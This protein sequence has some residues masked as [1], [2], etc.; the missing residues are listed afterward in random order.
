MPLQRSLTESV[1]V[2]TGASSGI[3]A[4]T[5]EALA[6][7]GA[8]VV[9]AARGADALDEIA[10]R[11]RA[12]GGRAHPVP[13]DV[14]DPAAVEALADA[15]T[16]RFGRLDGWVNNAGVALYARLAE[17]PLA[18]VRRVVDVNVFGYL[19]GI[20][21]AL[22]RLRQ[23][24]GG[25]I[26]NVASVLADVVTPYLGAYILTKHAVRALSTTVRQELTDDAISV[27]TVLPA[28]IDT[29]LYRHAANHLGRAARPI[30]PVFSPERVATVIVRVLHRPRR[31]VYA[32]SLARL[33]LWQRR[34]LPSLTER[35]AA[36][37]TPA[38]ALD[39]APVPA[40]T[41]NLFA[42]VP[43]EP[44]SERGSEIA[45]D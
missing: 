10:A 18:E 45:K 30:P 17:A 44:P 14:T 36:A 29:P 23:A 16:E 40:T 15:A 32:G 2:V 20:R 33:L 25:V 22:P 39:D 37:A 31:E 34:L 12:R 28:S 3:G 19:H 6:E 11:C 9:L 24:G 4:A 26:V 27:C 7:Q 35:I 1:V 38:V 21:A 13:T 41:G 43:G 42:P 8:R 5:A